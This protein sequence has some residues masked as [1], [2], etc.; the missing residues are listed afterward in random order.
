[1]FYIMFS[2]ATIIFHNIRT[3]YGKW[4]PSKVILSNKMQLEMKC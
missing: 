2:E 4:T 3:R 1:M